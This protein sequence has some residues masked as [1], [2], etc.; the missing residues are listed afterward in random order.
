MNVMLFVYALEFN[1]L[2]VI[3]FTSSANYV[4][5][6]PLRT[7]CESKSVSVMMYEMSLY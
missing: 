6:K 2:Q 7:H 4:T 3:Y 5:V 1:D